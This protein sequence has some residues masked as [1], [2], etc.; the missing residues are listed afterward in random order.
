MD[1]LSPSILPD[2]ID[3]LKGMVNT[4]ATELHAKSL[5]IEKL[6]HQLAV[7]RRGK[8]GTSSESLEQLDSAKAQSPAR[9]FTARRSGSR[10]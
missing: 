2:D 5:L 6:K 1:K 8:F 7:M 4:Q 10:T 3:A 9:A